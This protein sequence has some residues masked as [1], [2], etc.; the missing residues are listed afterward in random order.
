MILQKN[1]LPDT[2]YTVNNPFGKEGDTEAQVFNFKYMVKGE[3]SLLVINIRP[4]RK[5]DPLAKEK[6]YKRLIQ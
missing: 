1:V 4:W 5:Q 2:T 6:K 3:T